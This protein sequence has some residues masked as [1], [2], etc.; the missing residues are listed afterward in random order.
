MY[1]QIYI[2]KNKYIKLKH[3]HLPADVGKNGI[4]AHGRKQH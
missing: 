4:K 3:M 1:I 2:Y